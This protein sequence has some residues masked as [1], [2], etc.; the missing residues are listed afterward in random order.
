MKRDLNRLTAVKVAKIT[1]PGRYGDGGGLVLQVSQWSTKSLASFASSEAAANAKWDWVPCL[2][3]HL[4]R[5]EEKAAKLEKLL[6]EGVDPIEAREAERMRRQVT[7]RAVTFR[8]CAER[9]IA[10][11][12]ASWRNEKHR[13]RWK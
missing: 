2:R 5:R 4:P 11:H 12:E 13:E 3:F 8:E 7:E 9:Y 1:Q 10:A 6:L